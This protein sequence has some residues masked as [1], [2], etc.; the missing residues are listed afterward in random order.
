MFSNLKAMSL[1]ALIAGFGA[2]HYATDTSQAHENTSE[3][4]C[5]INTE[6][7]RGSLTLTGI[8]K[9]EPGQ[10]GQYRLTIKGGGASGTTSTSQGGA[11]EIGRDG[12]AEIGRVTLGNDGIY[13]ARLQYRIDGAS[14]ECETRIGD[15]I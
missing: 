8:A 9:G 14:F 11:F 15:H 13:D 6:T 10:A 1:A 2:V 3:N 5:A 12:K 4:A 7:G